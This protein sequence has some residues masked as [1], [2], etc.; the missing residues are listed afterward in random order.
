MTA[1]PLN[2]VDYDYDSLVVQ[3]QDRLRAGDSWQDIYRTG[4]GEM[5]IEFLA[6]VTSMGMFYTERRA[7]EVFLPTARHRTSVVNIVSVLNYQPR[8]ETSSTGSLTFGIVAPLTKIVYVPKYIECQSSDGT[9]FLTNESVAIEKGQTSVDVSCVQGELIQKEI[10]SNGAIEQS[11]LINDEHVENSA[12]TDNPTLRVVI[13][14]VEWSLV[15]SFLNSINTDKHYRIVNEPEGTVSVL[16]GDNI[17]GAAPALAA[18]IVIQYVRT[19]G[20]AGNVTYPAKI[21]TINSTLYDEDGTVATVTV[22]NADSF[23]GGSDQ[24]TLEDIQYSAP[25]VFSTG[26]RAVNRNDFTAILEGYSSVET[27]NTWGENEE[28]LAAGVAAVASMLNKVKMSLVL[29]NWELPSASFK[30]TLSAFIYDMSMQTVKYEFVTPV[31]LYVI[32]VLYITVSTGNS[33]S[34]TQADVSAVLA[35]QFLL[36]STTKLGTIIKY[37][38]VLSAINDLDGVS[39]VSMTLEIKKSLSSTYSSDSDWG[40]LLDAT[41]ILPESARVFVDGVYAVTDDDGGSGTGTFTASGISGTINY[42]TGLVLLDVAPAASTVYI[43]YQQDENS[44]IVPSFN[45]IAKL[46]TVDVQT[47]AMES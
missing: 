7:N 35:D 31:F 23:L 4:P 13:D 46:D 20:S 5:L 12:D 11:Y 32:P 26:D 30:A 38:N 28:A 15:S 41:D 24:E 21:T 33:L 37:S 16:F 2:Y 47:I 18:T 25:R 40:G 34:Q 9:K 14:G 8:R 45:E 22:T 19:L 17:R 36:G 6:A 10:S 43:R 39:Y 29:Q 27:A 42:S 3:I 44:N 1:N